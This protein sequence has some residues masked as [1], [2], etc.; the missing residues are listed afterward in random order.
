MSGQRPKIRKWDPRGG[1]G[2]EPGKHD[3]AKFG[4]MSPEQKVE[5]LVGM[6]AVIKQFGG[7]PKE[8]LRETLLSLS[9]E[10]KAALKADPKTQ[11]QLRAL[12]AML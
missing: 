12:M 7:D 3:P 8:M 9:N 5:T 6:I 4:D 10:Q 11:A 1:Q 2:D